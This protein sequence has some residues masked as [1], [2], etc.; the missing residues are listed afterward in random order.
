[1]G[2]Y[3]CKP[4]EK[5]FTDK[6]QPIS[7]CLVLSRNHQHIAQKWEQI[8]G[9]KLPLIT[10][11][12][13]EKVCGVSDTARAAVVWL[14]PHSGMRKRMGTWTL[15]GETQKFPGTHLGLQGEVGDA[16]KGSM[17]SPTM[18]GL[19]PPCQDLSPQ[20]QGF[21]CSRDPPRDAQ[22]PPQT[23]NPSSSLDHPQIQ[24]SSPLF[25]TPTQPT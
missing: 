3:L 2:F 23:P 4:E 14:C 5:L 22:P 21:S 13:P 24:R 20:H 9:G 17:N 18:L 10:Q 7:H 8:P 25:P 6:N 16:G 19:I 1:M 15:L 12:I 11:M